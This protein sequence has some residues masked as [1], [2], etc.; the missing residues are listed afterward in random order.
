MV[1]ETSALMKH[2]ISKHLGRRQDPAHSRKHQG[3][4]CKL[5]RCPNIKVG[6]ERSRTK[7]SFYTA[8]RIYS[9]VPE[10]LYP[11]INRQDLERE[12]VTDAVLILVQFLTDWVIVSV[13]PMSYAVC[14]E[15]WRRRPHNRW[16]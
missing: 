11:N 7:F 10:L 13:L 2:R 1:V 14:L 3:S 8:A 5:W 6:P 15:W 9:H 12:R 16:V 4:M